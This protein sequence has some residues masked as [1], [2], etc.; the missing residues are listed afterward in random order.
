MISGLGT[1]K[2]DKTMSGQFCTEPVA[3]EEARDIYRGEDLGARAVDL[4][5][6]EMLRAGYELLISD[7]HD[8]KIVEQPKTRQ[9]ARRI[10]RETQK[11]LDA[12]AAETKD[13]ADRAKAKAKDL[14][15]DHKCK[16]ALSWMRA[17]GGSAIL[18][19]ANDGTTDLKL[20][21]NL[22][23]VKSIDWLT[24]LEAADMQPLYYYNNPRADKYGEPAIWR[25]SPNASGIGAGI[26]PNSNQAPVEVHESRLIIF[27]GIVVSRRQTSLQNWWGDSIFTRLKPV[28]RSFGL[29]WS[30]VAIILQEF[31]LAYMKIKNLSEM[32]STDAQKKLA[33]RMAAVQLGRSVARVTLLDKEEEFGRDVASVAGL[34]DLLEKLMERLCAA[35]ETPVDVFMGMMPAGLNAT[36]DA[37][38]RL[39]YD[40]IASE[41]VEKLE[42]GM[43]K[44]YAM[45]L[46]T[47][48]GGKEPAKW[49]L[50]YKPL[51]QESPKEK[52]E[53][54]YLDAQTDE[55]NIANQ[56]Y[57]PQEARDSRYSG[58]KYG[59]EIIIDDVGEQD[60][61]SNQEI[62]TYQ[63]S[64]DPGNSVQKSSIPGATGVA[65]ASAAAFTGVQVTSMIDVVKAV[66][67]GEIPRE[68]GKAILM[69]AFPVDDAKA[70]E[71]LGPKGFEPTKP[72]PIVQP[73]A[74]PPN[75]IGKPAD[76]A[77]ENQK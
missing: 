62:E 74:K 60:N 59:T 4:W 5:P 61:F 39:F 46:R 22:D 26:D 1:D 42:P 28:L 44:V 65:S 34:A 6:R 41:R 73:G 16:Q 53:T 43:H 12:V 52:A 24:V 77:L 36:G 63:N 40:R 45:I 72:D 27:Q 51:W 17:Y 31:S 32:V 56:I 64:L 9:D 23:R 2:Y 76:P 19:G 7:A 68:S 35:V 18:I 38:V 70:E 29:G 11:R 55:K 20:P 54:R 10:A 33:A 30:S 21:L 71:L 47:L 58:D 49:C 37:S 57:T 14:G 67:N 69:V 3:W 15:L 8:E 66:L 50:E 25:I 75:P 13:L 48:N